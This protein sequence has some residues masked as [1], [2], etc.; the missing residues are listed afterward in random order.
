MISLKSQKRMSANPL[1]SFDRAV[2]PALEVEVAYATPVRQW[3]IT[4]AVPANATVSDAIGA[5][6]LQGLPV[7]DLPVLEGNVGIFARPCQ[8]SEGLKQGDRVE[9]YRPLIA[10]PMAQRRNR[11][12]VA[13]KLSIKN[14]AAKKAAL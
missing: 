11:A 1:S 5:A 2:K 4:V 13:N 12:V 7:Q 3:L 6:Y 8:L 10:D 9:I 14:A